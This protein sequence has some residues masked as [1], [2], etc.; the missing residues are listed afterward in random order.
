MAAT[1]VTL[2]VLKSLEDFLKGAY[3]FIVVG[4]GNSGLFSYA[5]AT[6]GFCKTNSEF[7]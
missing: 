4:G 3:D 5:V 2:P 1:A 7:F 6:I